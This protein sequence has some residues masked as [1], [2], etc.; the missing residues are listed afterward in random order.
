MAISKIPTKALGAGA[1]L[2]VVQTTAATVVT[3]NTSTFVSSGLSASITP[4]SSSNKILVM[5]TLPIAYGSQNYIVPAV[6]VTRGGT[7]VYT[8]NF[9]NSVAAIVLQFEI[10]NLAYLDSPA[11][12]SPTTYTVEF[13]RNAAVSQYGSL[14]VM[15]QSYTTN[16][17]VL[18]LQEIAG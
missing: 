6:R 5:V 16:T 15:D 3:N 11:T 4:S 1:V 8:Q 7:T 10:K 2:Q 17:G 14:A 13:A 18:L 12:T 9:G